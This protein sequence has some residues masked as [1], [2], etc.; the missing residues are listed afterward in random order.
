[1][2]VIR[3]GQLE[4]TFAPAWQVLKYDEPGSYYKT[5]LENK[6][7]PTKA[8]DFVCL[9]ANQPLVMLEAKDFSLA[10]PPREKFDKVPLAVALKARDTLAGIIG[11]AHCTARQD[12]LFFQNAYQC[13]AHPPRVI[14]FFEDLDTPARRPPQRAANKKDVLFKQLKE[15]LRWLTR[16]VVVVGLDD[17]HRMIPGLTIRRI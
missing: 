10:V 16:D 8:V 1:M 6:I 5:L 13:M 7:K 2:T 14:Y 11:G 3:E 12:R 17:Y 4:F 15:H 9:C